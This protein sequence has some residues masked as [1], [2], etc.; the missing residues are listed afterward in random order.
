MNVLIPGE[1]E[2]ISG[3]GHG[4]QINSMRTVNGVMYTCGIDDSVKQVDTAARAYTA[5]DVKLGS[6]PRGMDIS[7]DIV[8]TATIKEVGT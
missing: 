6:Q 2:R 8:V 3:T 4:N 7:G 1:T 5:V